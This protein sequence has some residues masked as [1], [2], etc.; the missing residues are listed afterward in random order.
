MTKC[1]TPDCLI[2][3]KSWT[4]IGDKMMNTSK[5]KYC[6]HCSPFGLHNTRPIVKDQLIPTEKTSF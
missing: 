2:E 3:I 6:L 4:R 1:A 5:R